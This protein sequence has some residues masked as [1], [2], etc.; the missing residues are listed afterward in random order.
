VDL[1]PGD[2]LKGVRSGHDSV[3]GAG[4]IVTLDVPART[5]VAGRPA[6]VVRSIEPPE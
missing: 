3:V 1:R 4:S 6:R 2:H 5:V